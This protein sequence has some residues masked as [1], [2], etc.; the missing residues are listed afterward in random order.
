MTFSHSNHFPK[1][2]VQIL[3]DDTKAVLR[4]FTPHK[5]ILPF[6]L[7]SWGDILFQ[8]GF[9]QEVTSSR[10]Y[11]TMQAFQYIVKNIDWH[12]ISIKDVHLNNFELMPSLSSILNPEMSVPSFNV[13]FKKFPQLC[14]YF[15]NRDISIREQFLCRIC[16][17]SWSTKIFRVLGLLQQWAENVM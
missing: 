5:L 9:R 11:C 2:Q 12:F 13:F 15:N 3:A 16:S 4:I 8:I 10:I 7:S 1:I 14:D 6:E 17:S